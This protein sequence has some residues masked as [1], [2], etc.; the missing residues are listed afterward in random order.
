MRQNRKTSQKI[1]AIIY[2][3]PNNDETSV[4]TVDSHGKLVTRKP[5]TFRMNDVMQENSRTELP[6]PQFHTTRKC[7]E[8][9]IPRASTESMLWA[10]LFDQSRSQGI[11]MNDFLSVIDARHGLESIF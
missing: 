11:P 8:D 6:I 2:C 3:H 10:N 7:T 5:Q 4:F 1:S 9:I